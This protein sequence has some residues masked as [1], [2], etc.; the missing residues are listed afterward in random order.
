LG[1]VGIPQNSFWKD[2]PA[3]TSWLMKGKLEPLRCM[4]FFPFVIRRSDIIAMRSYF[5]SIHNQPFL[6][7]FQHYSAGGKFSQ[8]NGMCA[9][10]WYEQ[11][12]FYHWNVR[13]TEKDWTL[14]SSN[15][16]GMS[17]DMKIYDA[18]ML[19]PLPRIAVHTRYHKTSISKLVE[20]GYCRSPPLA[21]NLPSRL[22]CS[23]YVNTSLF[24]DMHNFENT[25]FLAAED[26]NIAAKYQKDRFDRI[27]SCSHSYDLSLFPSLGH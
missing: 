13:V 11:K 3:S 22:D 23:K 16:P 14:K 12:D 26:K 17:T 27:S 18:W 20:E 21:K 24:R 8:F 15:V 1:R 5:E 7:I 10:L 4:S 25:D 9:Y 6:E 2:I 19:V